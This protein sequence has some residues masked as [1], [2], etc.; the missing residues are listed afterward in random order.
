MLCNDLEGW[1]GRVG[2]RLKREGIFVFIWLIY[3]VVQQKL[4]QHWK[5]VILQFK[6]KRPEKS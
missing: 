2:E 6:K 3:I 1:D 4:T 5:A